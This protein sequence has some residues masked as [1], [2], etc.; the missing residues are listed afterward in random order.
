[1]HRTFRAGFFARV[2]LAAVS[3]LV[4]FSFVSAKDGMTSSLLIG[5]ARIDIMVEGGTL[6]VPAEDV[7]GW[8][9]SAAES[10]AAYYG[11][12]PLPRVSIRITPF[13][14]RGV[15]NAM[16]FG[17]RGGRSTILLRNKTNCAGHG[18]E[19]TLSHESG[20]RGFSLLAGG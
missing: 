19:R 6:R 14:G 15:R 7:L 4:G 9:K 13:E 8:V 11:R 12:F 18:A 17:D 1:M 20:S 16:T 10:V 2:A 3:S 5:N